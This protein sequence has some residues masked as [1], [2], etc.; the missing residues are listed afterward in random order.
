MVDP[1]KAKVLT[2]ENL[3]IVKGFVGDSV[4]SN[5]ASDNFYTAGDEI[6]KIRGEIKDGIA[7]SVDRV[8]GTERANAVAVIDAFGKQFNAL[9]GQFTDDRKIMNE[10]KANPDLTPKEKAD[11]QREIRKVINQDSASFYRLWRTAKV[12]YKIR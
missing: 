6:S 9:S 2:W 7:R 10:I 5:Q 8:D 11:Y 3:P 4:Y 12:K 1:D